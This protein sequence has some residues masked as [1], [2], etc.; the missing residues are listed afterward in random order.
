VY[1]GCWLQV[2]E[3]ERVFMEH[4]REEEKGELPKLVMVSS[5]AVTM[6]SFETAAVT[7]HAAG[8]LNRVHPSQHA[9]TV[10]LN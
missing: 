3:L 2:Y 8:Q 7:L 6:F 10:R 4:L 5:C 1:A 9:A